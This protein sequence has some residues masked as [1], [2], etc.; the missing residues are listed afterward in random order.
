H[1]ELACNPR[2]VGLQGWEDV[3]EERTEDV[4]DLVDLDEPLELDRGLLRLTARVERDELELVGLAA[5]REAARLVDLVHRQRRALR[6][7]P[8]VD[9]IGPG[10]RLDLTDLD[11]V[12]RADRSDA[13]RHHG[14]NE[15][16]AS[17]D[18]HLRSPLYLPSERL[19]RASGARRSANHCS[20]LFS[21]TAAAAWR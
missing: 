16:E 6:R 10:L 7:H 17:H 12:L 14:E 11:H 18:R 1:E 19:R 15:E 21:L 4:L 2:R 3:G 8:A 9:G 5:H 13:E 20:V